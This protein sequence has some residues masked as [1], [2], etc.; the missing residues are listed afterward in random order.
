MCSWLISLELELYCETFRQNAI[1][2]QELFNMTSETLSSDLG[3]G[4]YEYCVVLCCV[5]VRNIIYSGGGGG[6]DIKWCGLLVWGFR[7]LYGSYTLIKFS[8]CLD[9]VDAFL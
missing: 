9:H 1:D 3:I 2:G 4:E 7:K 8:I 6:V 5:N